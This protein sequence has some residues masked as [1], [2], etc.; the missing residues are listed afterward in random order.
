MKPCPRCGWYQKAM[1]KNSKQNRLFVTMLLGLPL[2]A[3]MLLWGL[4]FMEE[5]VDGSEVWLAQRVAA[6]IAIAGTTSLAGM[7]WYRWHDPNHGLTPRERLNLASLSRELCLPHPEMDSPMGGQN[8]ANIAGGAPVPLRPS[9]PAET[10]VCPG[11]GLKWLAVIFFVTIACSGAAYGL[12]SRIEF[13]LN[14]VSAVARF[15]RAEKYQENGDFARAIA[16]YSNVIAFDSTSASVFRRR[17]DAYLNQGKFDNAIKDYTTAIRLRA[18]SLSFHNRGMAYRGKGDLDKALENLH[19]A[20]SLD[21]RN[22]VLYANRG[23]LWREQLNFEMAASDEA[24]AV[25][26]DPALASLV[27]K[28]SKPSAAG[29]LPTRA[30]SVSPASP[31]DPTKESEE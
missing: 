2:A 16:D 9:L 27:A 26:L 15:K 3:I 23:V 30:H 31:G 6:A 20:I 22:A 25:R 17:G 12:I 10:L 28:S 21:P 18:T 5:A 14:H 13:P 4:L 11:P 8:G 1:V 29:D 7:A 19:K 24:E